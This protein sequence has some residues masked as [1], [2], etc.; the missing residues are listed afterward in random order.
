MEEPVP[1]GRQLSDAASAGLDEK[2][3][4]A[5]VDN[6]TLEAVVDRGTAVGVREQPFQPVHSVADANS[7][8]TRP[9]ETDWVAWIRRSP[10]CPVK[11]IRLSPGSLPFASPNLQQKPR[12]QKASGKPALTR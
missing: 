4:T 3:D 11:S 12:R 5:L 9:Y 8:R 1:P 2:P 10:R 7:P 6:E